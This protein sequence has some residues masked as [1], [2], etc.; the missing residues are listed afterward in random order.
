MKTASVERN[1]LVVHVYPRAPK[2]LSV[3]LRNS[4]FRRR[5]IIVFDPDPAPREGS[6]SDSVVRLANHVQDV[7]MQANARVEH[8]CDGS[9][10]P[11]GKAASQKV[12][13]SHAGGSV[14]GSL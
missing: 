5:A 14:G 1:G 11:I 4:Q 2:L 12:I 3:A 8:H 10:S 9:P 7:S 6:K 13:Q